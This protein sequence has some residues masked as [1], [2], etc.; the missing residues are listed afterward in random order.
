MSPLAW[1]AFLGA[2]AIGAPSRYLL[3]GWI[4]DR[5]S[6]AFPWGT[7]TVNVTGCLALGVVAGLGLYHDLGGTV[8]TVLGTGGLGAYTTFSG[9]TFETIRLAEEGATNE[10]ARNVAANLLAGLAAVAAGLA[11]TAL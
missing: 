6:G 3:D 5:T 4:Q 11:L 2:A 1:A 9:F 8:R 7:F 10:A